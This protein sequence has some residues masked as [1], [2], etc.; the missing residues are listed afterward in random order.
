MKLIT[1]HVPDTY[2]DAIDELVEQDYYA[3]RADAIR[4]AIRD[5]LVSE[6]WAKR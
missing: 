3:S 4:S 5:L 2:L 1:V 6:V